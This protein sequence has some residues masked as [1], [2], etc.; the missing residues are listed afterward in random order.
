[1]GRA[2]QGEGWLNALSYLSKWSLVS[3]N[4]ASA[5]FYIN[6]LTFDNPM[7]CSLLVWMSG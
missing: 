4:E 2:M 1:M 5:N 7:P 3:S 6:S